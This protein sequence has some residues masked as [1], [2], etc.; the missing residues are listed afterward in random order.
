[1]INQFFPNENDTILVHLSRTPHVTLVTKLKEKLRAWSHTTNPLN[2]AENLEFFELLNNEALVTRLLDEE[3]ALQAQ[4]AFPGDPQL[5][6]YHVL[7]VLN[8]LHKINYSPAYKSRI[9]AIL[10][11]F[12]L[13]HQFG[14]T[15]FSSV[16]ILNTILAQHKPKHFASLKF[17]RETLEHLLHYVSVFV[18]RISPEPAWVMSN[19]LILKER[20]DDNDDRFYQSTILFRS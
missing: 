4:D 17:K 14:P 9:E 18:D 16:F 20:F 2:A 1:M 15:S 3:E 7:R 12:A 11:K 8:C 5:I 6:V 19:N 10:I 13:S